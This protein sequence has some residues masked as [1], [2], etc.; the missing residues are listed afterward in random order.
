MTVAIARPMATKPA[1]APQCARGGQES[2]EDR[3][4][5]EVGGEHAGGEVHDRRTEQRP[6]RRRLDP[7]SRS[8]VPSI[9]PK[10]RLLYEIANPVAM[11]TRRQHHQRGAE[12]G[13]QHD[14]RHRMMNPTGMMF[15]SGTTVARYCLDCC[16]FGR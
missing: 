2:G 3:F 14:R 5:E 15:A 16:T 4:G 12:R 7:V 9:G 11:A 1:T 8:S 13:E 6:L 10:C